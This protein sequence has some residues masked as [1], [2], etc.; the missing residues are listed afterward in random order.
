[1][2]EAPARHVVAVG[3]G[4]GGVGKS[5]IS[6]NTALALVE[7]GA[8][9]G[10]LDADFYGPDIPLMLGLKQTRPLERWG[11]WRAGGMR[12]EPVERFGLRVMSVGFMLAEQQ[13]LAWPGQMVEFVGRQLV[14]DV[15]W[16]E[17][18]YLVIDLPP[19][20]ADVQQQLVR[21]LPLA[22]F[23]LVVSPQDVA[24]LDAKR[25]WEMLTSERV[26]I[27]GAIENMRGLLC[28]HCGGHVEVFPEV[29]EKRSLWRLGV[30]RLGELP[31]DPALT[32]GGDRGQ[33]V[34]VGAPESAP[35]EAF[36]ALAG[37]VVREL[38][39]PPLTDA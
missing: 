38:E 14:H 25:L 31:L 7:R 5:T 12:L 1:M 21:L 20:T 10:L 23:P 13:A 4:K 29:S 27:L 18:D 28:P 36:R 37:R 22:A 24:H 9:V 34:V 2:K 26:R 3:S 6:L 32:V 15:E 39:Q 16:G 33:P 35:A 30:E 17:L 8:K 19:G 11:L